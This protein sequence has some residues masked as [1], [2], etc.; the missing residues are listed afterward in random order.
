MAGLVEHFERFLGSI[1]LGWTHDADGVEMPFQVVRFEKGSGSGTVGFA[2]L[3]LSRHGLPSV[4]SGREIRHQLL[5]LV[6]DSLRDGPMPA[7]LHQVG[8]RALTSERALLRGDV[9]GPQGPL[10]P[11]SSM[12]ALYVGMP[13]YF[14]D[15]FGS[16]EEDGHSV[17]IAW[18]IPISKLEAGYVARHGWGAFEERLVE[19]DPDLTD[20]YRPSMDL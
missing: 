16:C 18:L 17:V 15:E 3:G 14:P 8:M 4:T 1:Q 10:L 5:L 6:P 9:L 19:A 7:L 2:R 13:V 11:G 12:V 20:A